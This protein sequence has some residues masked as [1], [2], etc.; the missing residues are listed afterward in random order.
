MAGVAEGAFAK[1]LTTTC[2]RC[3]EGDFERTADQ[4]AHLLQCTDKAA[5]RAYK[6]KR[7]DE[8]AAT[9]AKAAKTDAQDAATSRA[10]F[11]FL[12]GRTQDVWRLNEPVRR[13]GRSIR[14][15]RPV[16]SKAGAVRVF[17]SLRDCRP[18]LVGS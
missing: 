17:T 8:E 9:S 6:R 3:G 2:P 1:G 18:R 16:V 14:S 12:G 13:P 15:C 11:D 7:Q 5:H 10:A 4:A